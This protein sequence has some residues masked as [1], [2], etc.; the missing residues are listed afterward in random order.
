ALNQRNKEVFDAYRL[1]VETG[2]LKLVAENPGNIASWS[3]DHD[4]NIRV[5]TTTD[6]VNTSLL[7]R[8]T[9]SDPWKTVIT[10][11]FKES[12]TPQFFTFETR[13]ST[14]CRTLAGIKRPLSNSI[15][16]QGKK[17]RSCSNSRMSTC[18][19]L[20]TRKSERSSRV[21][22]SRRGRK[23]ENFSIRLQRR[24]RIRSP[25]NCPGTIFTLSRRIKKKT[26]SSYA[27]SPTGRWG[28]FTC[29][30]RNRAN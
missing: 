27:P 7:Y 17:P 6:G 19:D 9:E 25:G 20:T 15:Q 23:N 10:T 2:D 5:A 29:T 22:V 28:R 11:N 1:N 8:K 3:T 24:F 4:G 30:I 16:K 13:R 26:R 21:R 18:P 14:V 12:F